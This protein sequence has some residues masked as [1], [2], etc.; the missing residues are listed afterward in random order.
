MVDVGLSI[1][2]KAGWLDPELLFHVQNA[3]NPTLE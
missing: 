1:A 2:T 3:E